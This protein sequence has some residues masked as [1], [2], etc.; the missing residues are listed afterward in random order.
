VVLDLKWFS[1]TVEGDDQGGDGKYKEKE[2]ATKKAGKRVINNLEP[3]RQQVSMVQHRVNKEKLQ[4]GKRKRMTNNL[5]L[6][7]LTT[8]QHGGDGRKAHTNKLQ[9]GKGNR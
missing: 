6:T 7:T 9:K 2:R 5:D 4:K 3:T 1:R 8:K